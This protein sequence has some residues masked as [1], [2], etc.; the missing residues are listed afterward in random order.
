MET[1]H[2]FKNVLIAVKAK[3]N[4]AAALAK[5]ISSWLHQ[6][7]YT[8]QVSV[9]GLHENPYQ[10]AHPDLVI[11]LG[12][13]GTVLA[14]ARA[15]IER[16]VPLVACNFGR[17][18]FLAEMKAEDWEENLAK[19]LAGQ[20][21]LAKRTALGW[22]IWRRGKILHHG[23]AINDVVVSR[24]ALSRV[25]SLEVQVDTEYI[26]TLRADGLIFSSPVGS[27]G[28]AVSAG[29]PLVHPANNVL[30]VTAICPYL[31]NFP[32]M[33]LPPSMPVR[34]T[35]LQC[36][37]E[38]YASIDGQENYLLE[39]QDIVEI[40]CMPETVH[41]AKL[42]EDRYFTPLRERGFIHGLK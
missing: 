39:T 30:M 31:C 24:G 2:K 20:F 7:D 17:V 33:V 40:F 6:R 5:E 16:P 41:F 15:F 13:D 8:V 35:I 3:H 4:E 38:T 29:G 32:A 37:N 23:Y 9:N 18:G 42:Q 36:S 22:R 12:G 11:V 26:S 28:Y 27:T 21:K 25:I 14:V 1:L 19:L 34:A 10:N